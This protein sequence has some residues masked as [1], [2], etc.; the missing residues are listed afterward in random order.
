LTDNLDELIN[1]SD[2]IFECAGDV[3]RAARLVEA[4]CQAG[5][6]VVS[7][8]A[9]FQATVGSYFADKG[10]V[11]EAEGDQPGSLAALREEAIDMGFQPLVYGNM[12][13]FLNH[14]PAPEEMRFWSERNGISLSKVTSFTDGTKLQ[15]EQALVANG[16]GAGIACR[17]LLGPKDEALDASA[18][19]LARL[20]KSRSC[21]L[22]DYVLNRNLPAGIFVVAE[23]AC[24]SPDVLR[25]LKLGEGPFYTL[26]RGYHLCH[27]EAFKTLRR[28]AQGGGAL[29]NNSEKPTI[30]VAAVAKRALLPGHEFECAIGGFDLRGEAVAF[31]EEPD[32]VPLGLLQGAVVKQAL[33]PGQTVQWDDVHL[34]EN[35][36]TEIGLKLRDRIA[37]NL[38]QR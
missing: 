22:S 37:V 14:N 35:F 34:P 2:I 33:E 31:A 17:G 18:S 8:A 16:L 26:S 1:D 19:N 6:P 21:H 7:L 11:T 12:K 3:E 28:V 23:H 25:Y 9:E 36:T 38:A 24:A 10:L 13:G 15:I 30:N 27:M 5:K 20:A 29:L 32:S 4:A